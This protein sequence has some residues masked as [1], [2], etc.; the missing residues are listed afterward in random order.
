L[1]KLNPMF[2]RLL[3]AIALILASPALAEPLP[4]LQQVEEALAAAPRGT[5]FGL[6]VV[7]EAGREIV[8]INPDMRFIPASNTKLFTTAAAYALLPGIDQPDVDGATRVVLRAGKRKGAPDVVL[9]GR[10]DSRMSV[11]PDCRIDCLATLADAVAARTRAVGNVIG[12]DTWFPDQRWSPGMS[13][14][15][16]GSNDATATSALTLDSNEL[17]VSAKPGQVGKPPLLVVP[18]YVSVRNEAVTVAP[19][20]RGRLVL[21]HTVNSRE[22]RLYGEV[23]A[24]AGE[25]RERIGIDDPAHFTAWTF[26][27][28]LKARGVVV[29]GQIRADHRP[30]VLVDEAAPQPASAEGAANGPQG[31]GATPPLATLAPP[32]LAQDVSI[33]NK[34][35]QNNHAETMLRRIGRLRGEG[36]LAHGLAAVR[37]MLD[38]AGVPRAGYDFSD[39]SGMST[40]NRLSPRASIGLLRWASSQPWG[41]QWYASLPLAGVD[42][43][44]KRRFIGTALQG[45]LAA[46]TGTLNA[47]N[48]LSG[49]FRART[50]K[51]LTFAFFA[52]D[53]PDGTSA[54]AAMEQALVRL[55]ETN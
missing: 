6:L 19:G 38:K 51:I 10:G 18:G 12:D 32:P 14:N 48:A 50:G 3:P 35:S 45:N 29:K 13:W 16:F 36:S 9:I 25:W 33:I 53:V 43:T 23:A 54:I 41:E 37:E 17:A 5:R 15:N 2:L 26:A 42:G 31:P 27:A 47:T 11:A 30:V 28:M 46:K 49:R 7:D 21:E 55:F 4:V 34:D 52:N 20:G 24:D 8:S 39:G 22:F 40:Y 1:G 44:L